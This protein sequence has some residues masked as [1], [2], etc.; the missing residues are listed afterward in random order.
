[1][2]VGAIARQ[3]VAGQAL[4][5]DPVARDGTNVRSRVIARLIETAPI[6]LAMEQ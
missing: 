6:A 3:T 1:M 5:T 2:E 4:I